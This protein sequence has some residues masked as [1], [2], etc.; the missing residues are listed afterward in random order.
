M[1]LKKIK[2]T[3]LSLL[4]MGLFVGCSS[5]ENASSKEVVAT[6]NGQDITVEEFEQ[7]YNIQKKSIEMLYGEEAL[8]KEISE[9]VTFAD[10]LKEDVL[11]QII[12]VNIMYKEAEKE[13]LLPTDKEVEEKYKEIKTQIDSDEEYKKS[14]EEAGVDDAY[15]KKEQKQILA[16]ENYQENF[17]KE[18]EVTDEEAKKYYDEHKDEFYIDEVR[19]SHILISTRN[20]NNEPLST[21]E[22]EKAKQKAE[23]ILAKVKAGEDFATLAK[24]NSDDPGSAANGG[25]LDFF[26]KGV[27]VEEFETAAFGLNVG[28]ISEIVETDFGYH[29]IKVTD[30]KQGQEPFEDVKEEIKTNLEQEEFTSNL[31][32]LTSE[33]KIEKNEEVL[34]KIK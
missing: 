9:G 26:G 25:D 16:L 28:E 15:I 2:L 10:Q 1:Y 17:L 22:K 29:I 13:K 27:M 21:K 6:V 23:E 20:E 24:E 12:D 8:T 4:V 31:E 3:V 7:V 30:K 33:A 32:K 14:L 19:A 18:H 11:Q 34:K 5:N